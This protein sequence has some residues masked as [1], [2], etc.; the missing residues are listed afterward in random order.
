MKKDGILYKLKNTFQR[1]KNIKKE[2]LKEYLKVMFRCINMYFT[3]TILISAILKLLFNESYVV[4]SAFLLKMY[5]FYIFW[6]FIFNELWDIKIMRK[7]SYITKC[8]IGTI[9]LYGVYFVLYNLY[10]CTLNE[11]VLYSK[12]FFVI[13]LFFNIWGYIRYKAYILSCDEIIEKLKEED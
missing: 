9:L 2:N 10:E 5:V 7:L 11:I 13:A 4:S 12:K 3:Y 1:I 6:W 8:I